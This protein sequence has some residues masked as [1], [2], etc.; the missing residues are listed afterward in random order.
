MTPVRQSRS[1]WSIRWNAALVA[2]LFLVFAPVQLLAQIDIFLK[3]G[4]IV[5]ES[6]DSVRQGYSIANA[7]SWGGIQ[8]AIDP[9]TRATKSTFHN[10]NITKPIDTATP[11]LML[12]CA[13]GNRFDRA[14]LIL[15][16]SGATPVEF[17]RIILEDVFISSVQDAGAVGDMPSENISLNFARIGVEYFQIT[18]KGTLG[19]RFE[20]AWDIANNKQG[21]VTFPTAADADADGL[22]DVWENQYGL[23]PTAN[24]A[25]LDPD[26]DGATNF[27][28]YIAGTSPIDANQVLRAKLN[29]ANPTAGATL[30]LPTVPGKTYRI[31]TSDSITG[32]FS[33]IQT[34]QAN[35]TTTTIA[36][37]INF[38][39]QYFKVEVVP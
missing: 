23:D 17:Y 10:L 6:R 5:G 32:P 16:K 14:T 21:G 12:A 33:P 20:F 38:P 15:R 26:G 24:D 7:W 37:A 11:R 9:L 19:N 31:L 3:V 1:P 39:T 8:N 4:D 25:N 22:P 28:E 27:E 30:M 29:L 35:D 36:A 18:P 2:A 34:F 13:R